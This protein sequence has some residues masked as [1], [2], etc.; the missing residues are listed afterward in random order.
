MTTRPTPI[1]TSNAPKILGS[2]DIKPRASR[3]RLP[4]TNDSVKNPLKSFPRRYDSI[5]EHTKAPDTVFNPLKSIFL[6][7]GNM[8]YLSVWGDFT[9]NELWRGI[10]ALIVA[11]REGVSPPLLVVNGEVRIGKN[12][13]DH[14]FYRVDIPLDVKKIT[15]DLPYELVI[16]DSTSYRRLISRFNELKSLGTPAKFILVEYSSGSPLFSLEKLSSNVLEDYYKL[17]VSL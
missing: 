13:F 2:L 10:G 17:K 15:G 16:E 8:W 12:N 1:P 9:K 7:G 4:L 5:Y 6:G 3:I 14:V 11:I